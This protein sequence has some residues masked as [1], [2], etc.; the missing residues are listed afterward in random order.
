MSSWVKKVDVVTLFVE[1]LVASKSFYETAF[2]LSL[3]YEDDNSAV[4]QF[5]NL[6]INLLKSGEA[7]AM[8]APAKVASHESGT[9]FQF[10]LGVDNV[11]E[12]CGELMAK[13]IALNNGPIDRP[14]GIRTAT[15][16]DPSGHLWEIAHDLPS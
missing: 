7:P 14:W 13:G 10:T 12:A 16:A 1:D 9:R 8:I 11:D 4:Y 5:E 2:G 15:I 6:M 3:V